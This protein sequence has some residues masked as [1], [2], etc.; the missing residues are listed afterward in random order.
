MAFFQMW[1][2]RRT[3]KLKRMKA[4]TCFSSI[5][6]AILLPLAGVAQTSLSLNQSSTGA[7]TG[8][9]T[10]LPSC[11]SPEDAL[12][13]D[14]QKQKFGCAVL[15]QPGDLT[16]GAHLV[17]GGS[18]PTVMGGTGAGTSPQVSL[19][20]H[21][22][23]SAGWLDVTTGSSPHKNAII[24]TISAGSPIASGDTWNCGIA[25]ANGA[26]AALN[27]NQAPYVPMPPAAAGASSAASA[28]GFTVMAN[29]Q[30]LAPSTEYIWR[31]WCVELK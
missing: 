25:A 1:T 29:A 9:W 4:S 6:I 17:L 27:N 21:S 18:T 10:T 28:A 16:N 5:A 30:N 8:A 22:S 31:Y 26:A 11:S 2:S 13:F 20:R 14:N 19:G 23:D 24:A 3:H 7:G 15:P 12:T